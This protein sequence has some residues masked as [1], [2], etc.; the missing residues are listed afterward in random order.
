MNY[1]MKQSGERIRQL[2]IQ[3]GCTQEELAKEMNIDR[4]L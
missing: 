2:R 4:S 1:D 3:S